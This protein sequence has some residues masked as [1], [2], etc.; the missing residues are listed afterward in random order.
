MSSLGRSL[1]AAVG[2]A[3]PLARGL[4]GPPPPP[5]EVPG[6]E[7]WRVSAF[8]GSRM[9]GGLSDENRI[10]TNLYGDGDWRLEGAL[11]RGDWYKTKDIVQM[12]RRRLRP[13]LHAARRRRCGARA[14][15]G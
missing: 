5:P 10:F 2:A 3:R 7:A 11:K 1:R 12:V 4:A 6:K 14:S 15:G 9:H 13:R 8:T